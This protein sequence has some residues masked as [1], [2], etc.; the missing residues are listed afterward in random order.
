MGVAVRIF[1]DDLAVFD[2]DNHKYVTE[3]H[4]IRTGQ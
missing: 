1:K 4:V 3:T 2:A